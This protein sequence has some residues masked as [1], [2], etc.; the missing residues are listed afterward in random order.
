MTPQ[1]WH[2]RVGQRVKAKR[3]RISIRKAAKRA[4]ISEGLWR[5]IE[6]G[7]R[8]LRNGDYETV[9]PKPETLASVATS[10]RWTEDSIERLLDGLEPVDL[11]PQVADLL[12]A[13]ELGRSFPIPPSLDSERLN[14]LRDEVQELGL[15]V[16]LLIHE[17]RGRLGVES[18]FAARL[19]ALE[20]ARAQRRSP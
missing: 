14:R 15:A 19:A 20:A 9:N 7:R 13:M 2:E 10:L 11:T 5:Q 4:G 17:A 3:G 1:E 12:D 8:P 6:S 16:D 18:D